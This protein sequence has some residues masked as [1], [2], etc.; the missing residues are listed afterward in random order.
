MGGEL[1]GDL[2]RQILVEA[3][4]LID[5]AEL[6]Q[7]RLGIVAKLLTFFR[8]FGHF[9]VGLGA[10]RDIFSCRH[11]HCAGDQPGDTGDNHGV[12]GGRRRRDA[13][14][15]TGRRDDPVIGPQHRRP[16]PADPVDEMYL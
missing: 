8:H 4:R 3:A 13:D 15:Q 2:H 9:G 14:Q 5:F 10:D 12:L 11:R 6:G 7:L 1:L 16:Q